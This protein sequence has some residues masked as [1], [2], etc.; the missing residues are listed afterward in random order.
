MSVSELDDAEQ[1]AV[2]EPDEVVDVSGVLA[3]IGARPRRILE[4]RYGLDGGDPRTLEEVAAELGISRQRVRKLETRTL[5]ELASHP[6][7]VAA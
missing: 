6:E 2:D 3:A 4:L 1:L 5:L 7:L